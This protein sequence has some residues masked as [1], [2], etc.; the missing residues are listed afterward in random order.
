[1]ARFTFRYEGI[2]GHPTGQKRPMTS[3]ASRTFSILAT[4]SYCLPSSYSLLVVQGAVIKVL[5]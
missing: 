1:M 5:T 3:I 2:S 4:M